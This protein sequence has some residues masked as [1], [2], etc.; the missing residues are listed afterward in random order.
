MRFRPLCLSL[1][2]ISVRKPHPVLTR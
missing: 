1:R 2:I